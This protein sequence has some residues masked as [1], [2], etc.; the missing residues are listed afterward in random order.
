VSD[1]PEVAVLWDRRG[2]EVA[3]ARDAIRASRLRPAWRDRHGG[4]GRALLLIAPATGSDAA[5]RVA[6]VGRRPIVLARLVEVHRN[7]IV[8]GEMVEVQFPS[9]LGA[10]PL[11]V[12]I[13]VHLQEPSALEH[14]TFK[15][16]YSLGALLAGLDLAR[17]E[18][19]IAPETPLKPSAQRPHPRGRAPRSLVSD[20]PH[21]RMVTIIDH[22]L[23][24]L[25]D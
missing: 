16:E 25:L 15:R 18:G 12:Q 23:D 13:R 14:V 17:S 10:E 20:R 6:V 8:L 22:V 19:S 3:L 4:R 9:R 1:T 5:Q 2:V 11:V 24:G 7:P 21:A